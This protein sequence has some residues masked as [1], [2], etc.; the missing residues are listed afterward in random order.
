MRDSAIAAIVEWT[1][2]LE[3]AIRDAQTEDA[4]DPAEDAAQLV[5]ELDAYLLLANAQYV[6][7]RDASALGRARVALQRRLAGAAPHS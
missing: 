2:L 1:D 6:I 4:I 3:A 5:F 7:S